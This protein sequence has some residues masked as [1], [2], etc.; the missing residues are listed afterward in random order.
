MVAFTRRNL[1]GASVIATVSNISVI[2]S[3]ESEGGIFSSI[4]AHVVR[5][6]DPSTA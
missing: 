2:H 6:L 4:V 5:S 3:E 1:R